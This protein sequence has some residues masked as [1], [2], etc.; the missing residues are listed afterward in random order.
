MKLIKKRL[1]KKSQ[2]GLYLQDTELA[3][4]TAFAPGTHFSYTIDKTS[5]QIIIKPSHKGNTVA[6]RASDKESRSIIHIRNKEALSL[7]QESEQLQISIFNDE[8]IVEGYVT[9]EAKVYKFPVAIK[10]SFSELAQVSG[11]FYQQN[12][13]DFL[14]EEEEI[15]PSLNSFLKVASLFSGAGLMD[16]GFLQEGYEVVFA[17]EHNEDAVQ[18]YR[19]NIGS[20]V[21]QVDIT[22]FDKSL[23]PDADVIIGGSPCQGFSNANRHAHFLDNPNNRLVREFIDSVKA[24]TAKVFVLENVPQILTAGD[25]QF[26]QEIYDEL[27]DFHINSGVLTASDY[28]S[29]QLRKRAIFIGSKIGPIE[30]PKPTFIEAAY[31]TVRDAFVGLSSLT[32]NQMDYSKS[33]EATIEKMSYVPPGGNIFDIPEDIRPKGT[34]SDVYKRLLWDEPSITIV[35][36]RK[37]MII[38]PEHNRILS[39]RECARL[40]DVPDDFVFQ[41]KLGSKQQQI[42][43]GVTVRLSQAIASKIKQAFTNLL[44]PKLVPAFT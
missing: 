42:A 12:L 24:S 20:H 17:L 32:P 38:H 43:N 28:G 4:Q 2:W 35:N 15:P 3:K 34:H 29:A 9:E 23:I 8:I 37:A 10:T 41:G 39:V 16:L 13:F 44:T 19:H 36:P 5:K 25:G 21:M 6:K 26:K 40:F 18:T 1:A 31:R 22:E 33:K 27:S 7:F 30:L 14:A 11:G